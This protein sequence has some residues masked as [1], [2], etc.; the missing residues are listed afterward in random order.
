MDNL[1]II[2]KVIEEHQTLRG[3]VKLVG[4]SIS[5]QEA[6]ASLTKART[7]WIPGRPE[8]MAEKQK[9]LQ[10]ALSSLDE[11]LKN[12]FDSEEEVLPSLLGELVMRAIILDHR[13]IIK[14]ID[15]AKSLAADI[16]I[17]GLSRDELMS[18]ESHIQ[19]VI[20]RISYLVEDHA[21]SEEVILRMAEKA[22]QDK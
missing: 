4:D 16:Q 15:K 8:I 14:E 7:D 20:N 18:Q 3:H 13:E 21:N 6:I 19:R 11:G 5:D 17:E 2:N 10:Q 22:L 9:R 12:H 1:A